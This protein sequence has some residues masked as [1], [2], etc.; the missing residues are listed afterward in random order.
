MLSLPHVRRNTVRSEA[1][2]PARRLVVA[3]ATVAVALVATATAALGA[4]GFD[5][6]V[7]GSPEPPATNANWLTVVNFYRSMGGVPA[8]TE[9]TGFSAD[10]DLHAQY[11]AE[12]GNFTHDEDPDSGS[13]NS[14]GD[15]AGRRAAITTG[16]CSVR[17]AIDAMMRQPFN[18]ARIMDQKL[19]T[20]GFGIHNSGGTCAA[21]LDVVRGRT[22]VGAVATATWPANGSTVG[23]SS[24][25]PAPLIEQLPDPTT[26]CP[27]D[28]V[29]LPLIAYLP[30]DA[31]GA[32]SQVLKRDGVAVDACS[33]DRFTYENTDNVN[34][35]ADTIVPTNAGTLQDIGR[36]LL[37]GPAVRRNAVVLFPRDALSPGS[38]YEATVTRGADTVTWTF[39]A[40]PPNRILDT[41]I[42]NGGPATKIAAGTSRRVKVAGRGGLPGPGIGAV[43]LNVTIVNPTATSFLTVFP[44]GN[45]RPLASNMNF[46]AG[47]IRANLVMVKLSN[48]GGMGATDGSVEIYNDKGSTDVVVDVVGWYE[49]DLTPEAGEF[50]PINPTA[51][52]KPRVLDTRSGLGA[53]V[54]KV[55]PGGSVNLLLATRAGLPAAGAISAVVLNLTATDATATSQLVSYPRGEGRPPS[56]NLN[57][58]AN[59]TVAN[60]VVV[61]VSQDASFLGRVNIDNIAG[62]THVVADVVGY[63]KRGGAVGDGGFV[64]STVSGSSATNGPRIMD[65]RTGR[66]TATNTPGKVG[67]DTAVS[68][69]VLGVGGVPNSGVDSVVLNV[70][71]TQPTATSFLTAYP[72]GA[73]R[74]PQFSNMN[75]LANQTLA[76]LVV[77]KVGTGGMVDLYNRLGSTHIVVDV[78]GYFLS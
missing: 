30:T 70:T 55:G 15:F 36:E 7:P 10:A 12:T 44:A 66:G 72:T 61:R 47:Q 24:V 73:A 14:E 69:K 4:P 19:L 50:T 56:S 32:L 57:F 39:R 27:D 13:F 5:I 76:N 8:L 34:Y 60:L 23:L 49:E 17:E 26:T 45:Q 9:D 52:V 29:G 74:P 20:S 2:R 3:A 53:P 77:V 59:Q 68:L 41:R 62:S 21:A 31:A 16:Q 71:I 78:Q 22:G 75:Y 43:A 35:P 63:F 1:D 38:T 18:A 11:M 37:R 67:A 46:T 28:Y 65:T 6:A 64:P 51:S 54:G 25:L 58:T 33:F 48:S 42:G 40:E